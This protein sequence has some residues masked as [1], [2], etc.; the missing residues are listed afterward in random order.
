MTYQ[1]KLFE[2]T[3]MHENFNFIMKLDYA[4]GLDK[5]KKN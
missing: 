5:R 4:K 2:M 1:S 3:S